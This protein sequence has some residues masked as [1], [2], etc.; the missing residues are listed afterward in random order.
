MRNLKNWY[1]EDNWD[2]ERFGIRKESLKDLLIEKSMKL[3]SKRGIVILP[4]YLNRQIQNELSIIQDYIEGL[5]ITY[6]LLEDEYS[7]SMLVKVITYRIM[8][9]RKVKLP[10]NNPSYWSQRNLVHSLT[11]NND[12][13][14][15]KFFDWRLHHFELDKIGISLNLYSMVGGILTNFV[16]KQY[17][18]VNRKFS[19]KAQYGDYVIDAGGSW[20]DT[21][22][23]FSEEVGSEGKVFTFEFIP[24]NID[25]MIK[26]FGLNPEL[27]NRIEIIQSPLW[28]ESGITMFCNDNGPGSR[29]SDL[30][31]NQDDIQINTLSID[32]FVLKNKLPRI[33]FIKMDIEGAELAALKGA[34]ETLNK[35]KPKLA[36]SI[37][38]NLDDYVQIPLFLSSLKLGYKFYIDHFTIHAEETVLFAGV[39]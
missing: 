3:F 22:L 25:I 11:R 14:K 33:D 18:Y 12:T 28:S 9:Y 1:G 2:F 27:Q 20:G 31:I 7:K 38:H 17:E 37:Y 15:I 35:Y 23:Y 36:I 13:I 30:R 10:L 39:T 4:R 21:A 26:N 16:L 8:G 34:I 19:I 29:V 6:S 5:S 32:D 24:S